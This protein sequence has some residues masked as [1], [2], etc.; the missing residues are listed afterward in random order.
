MFAPGVRG[1]LDITWTHPPPH[2]NS[3]L[4]AL[5]R[6]RAIS[7]ATPD[8]SGVWRFREVL[9]FARD[10]SVVSLNEGNT[11]LYDA[12]RCAAYCQI[13]SLTN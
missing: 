3:T 10:V 9:P 4:R 1:L 2:D 8:R 7:Q 13:D 6:A 11:P 12:T 5:W